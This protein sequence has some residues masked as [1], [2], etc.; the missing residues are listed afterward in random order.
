MNMG[1]I[2]YTIMAILAIGNALFAAVNPPNKFSGI[3]GW[4]VAALWAA[5]A[6]II[7]SKL[8]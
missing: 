3:I 1:V 2:F 7:T 6:A 4:T 5:S 8:G